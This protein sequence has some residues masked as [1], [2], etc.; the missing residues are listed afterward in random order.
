MMRDAV[1]DS[2]G[3]VKNIVNVISREDNTYMYVGHMGTL[4]A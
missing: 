3:G 4:I 1:F 2:V